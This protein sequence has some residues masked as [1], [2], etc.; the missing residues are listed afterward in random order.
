MRRYIPYI[1]FKAEYVCLV[2]Q[3]PQL[4][5]TAEIAR[6]ADIGPTA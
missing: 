3:E 5:I 1:R 2:K 4:T 6:D